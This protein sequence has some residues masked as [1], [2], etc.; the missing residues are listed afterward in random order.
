MLRWSFIFGLSSSVFVFTDLH[1]I[2]RGRELLLASLLVLVPPADS[3]RF[4]GGLAVSAGLCH[5]CWFMFA[6][7]TL[8]NWTAGI[9]TTGDLNYPKEL[10][11]N[12]IQQSLMAS[13]GLTCRCWFVDGV[14]AA[15][16]CDLPCWYPDN[17][18]RICSKE[19]FSNRSTYPVSS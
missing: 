14:C 19:L 6:I 3:C 4:G 2:E 9:L 10:L 7:L 8:L 5:H 16:S 18:D 15:D 11:L 17:A 13:S 12:S 1:F